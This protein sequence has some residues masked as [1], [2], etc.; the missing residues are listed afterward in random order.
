M[1]IGLLAKPLMVGGKKEKDEH[2]GNR[3]KW[4]VPDLVK[5]FQDHLFREGSAQDSGHSWKKSW[6]RGRKK[7]KKKG[8]YVASD[9]NEVIQK[10]DIDLIIELTGHEEIFYDILAKKKRR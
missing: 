7:A 5:K 10:E 4:G 8:I 6:F 9:Y 1:A 3:R 2:F